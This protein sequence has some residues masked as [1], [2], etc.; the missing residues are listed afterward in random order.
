MKYYDENAKIFFE[1]TVDADMKDAYVIF[2]KYIKKES[3]IVDIGCGSGRDSKYFKDK[4]YKIT[5]TDISMELSK[6]AEKL[7]GQ[8]VLIQNVV[9]MNEVEEYDAVWACA[10]LLHVSKKNILKALKNLY[11]SLK[12]GGVMYA[13]FKYGEGEREAENRVFNNYKEETM[14][15][16]LNETNFKLK[17]MWI[18]GDVRAGRENEKW[19]NIIVAK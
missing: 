9:N 4:G 7:I 6:L 1:T 8:E 15:E 5:A 2:E 10:S 11:I 16:L 3:H 14:K 18:T 17:E 12:T 19:L 13:S